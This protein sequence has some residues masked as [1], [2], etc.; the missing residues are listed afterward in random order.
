MD[1]VAIQSE[2]MDTVAIQSED[3]VPFIIS[4]EDLQKMFTVVDDHVRE[5]AHLNW[6]I[7]NLNWTP[8]PK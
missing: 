1:T 6:M 3:T 4:D 5:L 8:N 2:V 7:P